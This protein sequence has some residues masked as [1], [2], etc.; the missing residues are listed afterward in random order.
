LKNKI[1][2]NAQA[3]DKPV[4]ALLGDLKQRGLL[5]DTLVV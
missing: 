1:T 4:A 5:K 2:S 3:I